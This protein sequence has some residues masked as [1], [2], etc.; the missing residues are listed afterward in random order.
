MATT[1]LPQ[2]PIDATLATLA[3]AMRLQFAAEPA[4]V[5]AA[6]RALE[7]LQSNLPYEFDGVELRVLSH[8]RSKEGLWQVT[9]GIGCTCEGHRRPW[10][11][12]RALFRLL[13]AQWSM[14]QPGYLRAKI[15]EQT[16]PE[17]VGDDW[18]TQGDFL[19]QPARAVAPAV[20]SRWARSQDAADALF[21]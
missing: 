9:D 11:R 7:I 1:M 8:S 20:G 15:I 12:H 3:A 5:R 19:A 6:D 21:A 4:A 17:D 16:S 18:D 14:T 13:L 10:C 2:Y